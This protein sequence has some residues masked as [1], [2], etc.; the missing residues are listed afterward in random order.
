MAKRHQVL[1]ILGFIYVASKFAPGIWK[2]EVFEL[3][4][5][6]IGYS[7]SIFISMIFV[8]I[9]VLTVKKKEFRLRG[10]YIETGTLAIIYGMVTILFGLAFFVLELVSMLGIEF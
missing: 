5:E 4:S 9:G 2:G 10:G 3:I 7:F 1:L 8:I 6:F